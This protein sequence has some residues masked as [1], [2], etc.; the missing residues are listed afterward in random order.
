MDEAAQGF[1]L[2][3]A[4]RQLLQAAAPIQVQAPESCDLADAVREPLQAPAL[5]IVTQDYTAD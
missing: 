3:D 5:I 1:E 2:A 4:G